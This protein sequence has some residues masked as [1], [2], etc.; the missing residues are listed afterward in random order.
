MKCFILSAVL[1]S[2]AMF[3][4]EDEIEPFCRCTVVLI[5]DNK[6]IEEYEIPVNLPHDDCDDHGCGEKCRV[7]VNKWTNNGDLNAKPEE[8]SGLS[9]G[10]FG[11]KL[12]GMDIENAHARIYATACNQPNKILTFFNFKQKFCCRNGKHEDKCA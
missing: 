1:L 10:D 7:A 3:R 2:I 9:V 8:L 11:C 6:I 5:G 12:F 4:C